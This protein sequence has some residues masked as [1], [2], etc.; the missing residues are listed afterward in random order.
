MAMRSHATTVFGPRISTTL[1]MFPRRSWSD[2]VALM[3][4]FIVS[5]DGPGSGENDSDR[6]SSSHE[7]GEQDIEQE[8]LQ[9]ATNNDDH[10]Q[11]A[12]GSPPES[13]TNNADRDRR[14]SV[15]SEL[16]SLGD[17][18]RQK[19]TAS[20]LGVAPRRSWLA[21]RLPGARR[22]LSVSP[23]KEEQCG[24]NSSVEAQNMLARRS[25][26][27]GARRSWS[28][29]A[30]PFIMGSENE[31]K[32]FTGGLFE[33][34]SSTG[35]TGE[36]TSPTGRLNE[37]LGVSRSS[38]I[39]NR[40]ATWH[41][42]KDD[43]EFELSIRGKLYKAEKRADAAGFWFTIVPLAVG[44]TIISVTI[45]FWM[46][47]K[48]PFVCAI[49][50]PA[51]TM[52]F[53]VLPTDRL[54]IKVA[55]MMLFIPYAAAGCWLLYLASDALNK[56]SDDD[57]KCPADRMDKRLE[58]DVL[59]SCTWVRI[60]AFRHLFTGLMLLSVCIYMVASEHFLR[61]SSR[62]RWTPLT[63]LCKIAGGVL[64]IAAISSLARIIALTALFA[65]NKT[66]KAP[67]VYVEGWAIVL[68]CFTFGFLLLFPGHI[69][70]KLRTWLLS[71]RE[72][73]TAASI[74]GFLEGHSPA[75]VH[76]TARKSFRGVRLDMVEKE[77]MQ[78]PV[79]DPSLYK[80]TFPV[81]LGL[82]DAFVTHSWQDNPQMKWA[83]IQYF[84][85]EFRKA[86]GREAIVWIDK[87]CINQD[88]QDS[89]KEGLMCLPV[90]LGK[91]DF[92]FSRP[93][94]YTHTHSYFLLIPHLSVSRKLVASRCLFLR[95]RRMQDA[96]GVSR[97]CSFSL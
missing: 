26:S 79:P 73:G 93:F 29:G 74:A 58:S 65:R 44:F 61:R 70:T 62:Q 64:F 77:A 8:C 52:L 94:T 78:S 17:R 95:A 80:L 40:A 47:L 87:Y 89:V 39:S 24:P 96:C 59:V 56:L 54:A 53:F 3:Q 43:A 85:D 2:M 46:Y 15:V 20:E 23:E 33:W 11:S 60:T 38:P 45:G 30:R 32:S 12:A 25:W 4:T 88:S 31:R 92:I 16:I 41:S 18:N 97:S 34:R 81:T 51:G 68:S 66:H 1:A 72:H 91:R 83:Q 19:S 49:A 69:K 57:G 6:E 82:V 67:L 13:P 71:K 37:R 36:N 7:E 35:A 5:D 48:Y 21:I 55:Y 27:L 9:S 90:F 50:P 42:D 28:S 22:S 76:A 84:R 75:F 63:K 14:Q 86:H 10:D